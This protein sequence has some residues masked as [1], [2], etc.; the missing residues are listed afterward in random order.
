MLDHMMLSHQEMSFL[1]VDTLCMI[2]KFSNRI[3][4]FKLTLL[5]VATA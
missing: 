1:C 5:T 2:L 4:F 3:L